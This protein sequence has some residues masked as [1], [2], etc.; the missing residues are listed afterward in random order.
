MAIP[1]GEYVVKGGTFHGYPLDNDQ[2]PERPWWR[3][4]GS[5][6]SKDAQWAPTGRKEGEE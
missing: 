2:H 6:Q 1:D 5:W 3:R 4:D